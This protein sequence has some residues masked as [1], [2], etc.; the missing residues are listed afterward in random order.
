VGSFQYTGNRIEIENLY[1]NGFYSGDFYSSP[2]ASFIVL[3][4]EDHCRKRNGKM[5]GNIETTATKYRN[6]ALSHH[7]DFNRDIFKNLIPHEQVDGINKV[8]VHPSG[9]L[10]NFKAELSVS[11]QLFK[12]ST[13]ESYFNNLGTL[14]AGAEP[15]G[16]I[17]FV[18]A[19]DQ[20]KKGLTL[21]RSI[22]GCEGAVVVSCG[23]L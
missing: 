23:G 21:S 20:V 4:S 19:K 9:T 15:F 10:E 22:G 17:M 13:V 1:I 6:V 11:Q 14:L 16:I 5:L 7:I 2:S 8:I 12:N 3:E 18:L